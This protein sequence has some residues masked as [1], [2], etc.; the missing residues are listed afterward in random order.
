[1]SEESLQKLIELAQ[2][3]E[4]DNRKFYGGNNAAGTRLR[5]GLQEVKKLA[6]DMRNEVTATKASRTG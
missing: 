4:E 3:L 6:Q 5:K 2:S 1:M